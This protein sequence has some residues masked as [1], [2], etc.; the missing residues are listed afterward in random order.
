LY[1]FF[2]RLRQ[3][4]PGEGNSGCQADEDE[5]QT[6]KGLTHLKSN[7]TI[8]QGAPLSASNRRDHEVYDSG[9]TPPATQSFRACN[10]LHTPN[11]S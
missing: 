5:E 4:L 2:C 10:E 6:N 7:Q 1:F 8:A 9:A 3:S 11:D